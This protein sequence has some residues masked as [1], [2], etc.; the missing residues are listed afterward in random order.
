MGA[1]LGASEPANSYKSLTPRVR[2]RELSP[3][4]KKACCQPQRAAACCQP[5][6]AADA[7]IVNAR[8]FTESRPKSTVICNWALPALPLKVRDADSESTGLPED[9]SGLP[10]CDSLARDAD[11]AVAVSYEGDKSPDGLRHGWGIC[12][13]S[14]GSSYRGEWQHGEQHGLG[15][16]LG[17]S[18]EQHYGQYAHGHTH[19]YGTAILNGGDRYE[20]D[21]RM[22]QITGYGV[23]FFANGD[24]CLGDFVD[25][26][27]QGRGTFFWKSGECYDG[28]FID[29]QRQKVGGVFFQDNGDLD[30]DLLDDESV[31]WSADGTQMWHSAGV[32]MPSGDVFDDVAEACSRLSGPSRERLIEVFAGPPAKPAPNMILISEDVAGQ[33]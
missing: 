30:I 27:L 9:G 1:V 2:S 21:F 31:G 12:V 11:L 25:G 19:G 7:G 4:P 26:E 28:T 24:V 29:G 32:P 15:A 3:Q 5:Q 14:D 33:P 23:R 13:F 6:R 20:G 10:D 8:E 17:L 18:H 22:G 16:T